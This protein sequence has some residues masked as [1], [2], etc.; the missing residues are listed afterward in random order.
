M[1]TI[2]YCTRTKNDAFKDHLIKS[3]GLGERNIEVIEIVNT[4]NKSLTECYNEILKTAKNDYV[5]FT[6]SD[7][8]LETK[9]WG[10]KL[11]KLFER[12]KHIGIIGVAGTKEMPASGCWWENKRKMYGR[13]AH[14]SGDKTWLS[15]YSDD[16]GHEI[17]E[18]VVVDGVFFAVE[19][20]RIKT[21]F[22]E[23][24]DGFHFYDISFTFENH[25]LGVGVGVTT[26]IR[27]NHASIGQTNEAWESHRKL[28]IKK[29][30]GNLP[31]SIKRK[32]RKG[33]ELNVLLTSLNFDDTNPKS[34]IVLEIASKL[35]EAKHRVS[36]CANISGKIA[37]LAK[38]KGVVLYPIQQ[39]P[40]FALG[41]G[42]FL[43]NT[44]TGK[45]PSDTKTLYR[46]KD[47]KFD[48]I[49]TFDDELV[50]HMYKLYGD[51]PIVDTNFPNSLFAGNGNELAKKTATLSNDLNDVK[52]SDINQI[53]NTYLDAF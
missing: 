30:E 12:N 36:L 46:L 5:V 20:N 16:L 49:H 25:L 33:E 26:L 23:E 21:H 38:Q 34:N 45:K 8:T 22:N 42:K 3:C 48:V 39:P 28:F 18:T 19:K 10:A 9:Q 51:T 7:L 53:I 43:V 32:L 15:A 35:I 44:P 41:N 1:I 52:T 6:H 31:V 2:G 40:G 47:Y 24:F 13:V 37:N 4:G 50:S 11:I 29:Y 27:V 17:E 14:T